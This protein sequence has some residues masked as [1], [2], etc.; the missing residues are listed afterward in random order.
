MRSPATEQ[1]E[2]PRIMTARSCLAIVCVS[3]LTCPASA[4]TGDLKHPDWHP[5]GNLLIAEGS[6]LGNIDLFLI[7]L[8]RASVHLAW[9]SGQNEGYPRWFAD[10][11]R[12]AF[13]QID[14]TRQARL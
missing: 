5:G 2:R 9:D 7:D 13:H 8:D 1:Q 14:D 11:E 10:G 12:L 6:C 4:A 3:F